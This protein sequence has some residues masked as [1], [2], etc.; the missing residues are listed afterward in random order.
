MTS[1]TIRN[2]EEPIK[3]RP[4]SQIDA[5]IAAITCSHNATLATWNIDDFEECGLDIINPWE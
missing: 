1:L 2:L 5:Q 4:I 3:G